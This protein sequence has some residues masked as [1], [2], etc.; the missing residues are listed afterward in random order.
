MKK[1]NTTEQK[2]KEAAKKVFIK[3]G[4]AGARMQDIADQAGINK[5]LLHYYFRSKEKLFEIIFDESVQ[6]L[7]PQLN[8]ILEKDAPVLEKI[9][10]FATFYIDNLLQNPHMPLFVIHEASQ[11]PQR[12]VRKIRALKSKPEPAVFI[13]QVQ[14]E[15]AA[16]V[17]KP[18]DPMHLFIHVVSLCIFPFVARP[19]LKAIAHMDDRTFAMLMEQR[20]KEVPLF[21][22]AAV[23]R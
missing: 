17:L 10:G 1:D 5:A 4:L 23:R 7:M 15:I 19:M 13:K 18:V 22:E 8:S 6:V 3:K 9:K 12:L 14:Q 16:G 21:I 2:I 11:N 20:K